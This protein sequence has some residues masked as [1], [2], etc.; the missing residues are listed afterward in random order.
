MQAVG[1][2]DEPSEDLLERNHNTH[3]LIRKDLGF[4]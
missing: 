3:T 2:V 1:A 4:Y